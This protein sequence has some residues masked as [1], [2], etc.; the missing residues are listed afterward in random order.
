MKANPISI[1]VVTISRQYIDPPFSVLRL[2][3]HREII[4]RYIA[5]LN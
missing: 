4:C 1:P 3:S 5:T 2:L